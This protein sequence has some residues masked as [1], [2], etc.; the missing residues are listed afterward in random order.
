MKFFKHILFSLCLVCSLSILWACN[1]TDSKI[2]E[3]NIEENSVTLTVEQYSDFSYENIVVK[4]KYDDGSEKVLDNVTFTQID[5]QVVGPQ[6]L[7]ATYDKF[8]DDITITVTAFTG[9]RDYY[10]DAI[11]SPHFVSVFN[12]YSNTE[13]TYT[14]QLKQVLNT[15]DTKAGFINTNGGSYIYK[16]GDDNNFKFSPTISVS[17]FNED[18]DPADITNFPIHLDLYLYNTTSH[19]YEKVDNNLYLDSFDKN[20]HTMDFNTAAIGKQF[21]IAVRPDFDLII[22]TDNFS[23]DSPTVVDSVNNTF[24][25]ITFE[26]EVIDAYNVYTAADLSV[27]D[28]CDARIENKDSED[29]FDGTYS[30]NGKWSTDNNTKNF[31]NKAVSDATNGI[32][33]HDDINITQND[34]PSVHFYSST[35][36]DGY[37]DTDLKPL[38]GKMINDDN[39]TTL[40][41]VYKRVIKD[42]QTFN[43]EGNYW[44][45]SVKDLPL[46]KDV[47]D[48]GTADE[49]I[50]VCTTLFGFIDENTEFRDFESN[51]QTA[52]DIGYFDNNEETCNINNVSFYG[53][54]NKS[55]QVNSAEAGLCCYKTE[56]VNFNMT[57]CLSQKWYIAHFFE[58]SSL[59]GD[60]VTHKLT[61]CTSFDSF[62]CLLYAQG[63]R[64]VVLENCIMIGAGGPVMICDEETDNYDFNGDKKYETTEHSYNYA[65]NFNL[66]SNP[67]A[68]LSEVIPHTTNVTTKDCI[69]ESWVVGTEA[70]F[71]QFKAGSIVS[72]LQAKDDLIKTNGGTICDTNKDG[73]S[74][75]NIIAVFKSSSVA[76]LSTVTIDGTFKDISENTNKELL[77]SQCLDVSPEHTQSL[78][79]ST[80]QSLNSADKD[81]P[82][83][84]A[85]AVMLECSNGKTAVPL[86]SE[87]IVNPTGTFESGYLNVYLFN[88]MGAVL[89]LNSYTP[90]A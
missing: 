53:N 23:S 22:G 48:A 31:Y 69:L 67:T 8:T 57:N 54:S 89:E 75:I 77:Y 85:N 12:T 41:I 87:W 35:N 1:K 34:I 38:L 10:I 55:E 62:N 58:G 68:T 83:Y 43:F 60:G 70:W 21:K 11:K 9:V 42:G 46:V 64:N 3:I 52:V 14:D 65:H 36:T 47:T 86:T 2:T 25:P 80:I 71:T 82:T 56:N 18:K 15:G 33:L 49:A 73:F 16:V 6:T 74:V 5:T 7:T 19:E 24:K 27:I 84:L 63:A 61:D 32:V 20:N 81:I 37:N 78:Y 4:A 50:V 51:K 28:N 76:G 72:S 66:A 13:N 29:K 90:A 39:Y 26:I 59:T 44:T 40:G 45:I 17:Y 30:V 88:G 79:N